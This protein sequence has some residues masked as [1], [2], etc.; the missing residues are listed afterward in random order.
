ML[1]T[2]AGLLQHTVPEQVVTI[3]ECSNSE[4]PR[5]PVIAH[6]LSISRR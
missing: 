6:S 1:D 3:A 4:G 5:S 2:S